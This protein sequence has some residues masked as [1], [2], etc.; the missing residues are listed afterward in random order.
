MVHQHLSMVTIILVNKEKIHIGVGMKLLI[1]LD[2][3]YV[4]VIDEIKFL[5]GGRTNRKLQLEIIKAIK[6][7]KPLEQEPT[8]KNDLA[9]DR[10]ISDCEKMSFDIEIFNKPLK[11]VALDAVKNIVKGM[12]LVT[13]IRPKGHW[14]KIEL[15]SRDAHECSECG[16]LAFLDECGNEKLT[17]F[18]PNCGADMREVEE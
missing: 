10:L 16:G 12:S 7:G 1:E 14:I 6:N 15:P 2:E 8:T 4:K 17:D 5:V 18:C 11:V 9:V 13:P 3:E